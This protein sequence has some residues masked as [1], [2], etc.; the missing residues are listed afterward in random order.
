MLVAVFAGGVVGALARAALVELLPPDPGAWPWATF[1]ANIAGA[2]LLGYVLARLHE[3]GAGPGYA[4][5]FLTT[6]LCGAL[7]TF[8]TLQL[9]LLEMLDDAHLLLALAYVSASVG[10]GL[11]AAALASSIGRRAQVA[12]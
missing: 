4:R 10:C 12:G 5:P 7:T 11:A 9:E 1:A 6:G 8:S 2:L 3:P